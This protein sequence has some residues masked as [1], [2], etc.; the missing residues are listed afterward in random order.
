MH[1][2]RRGTDRMVG[3]I[4]RENPGMLGLAR[5]LGFREDRSAPNP[6]P[7]VAHVVLPLQ[8]PLRPG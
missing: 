6:D 7:E 8:D 5:A 1:A 3:D 2:R 4:L